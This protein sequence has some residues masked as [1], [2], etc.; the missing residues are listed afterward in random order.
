MK[1]TLLSIISALLITN[2]PVPAAVAA[3][4]NYF[5]LSTYST[6]FFYHNSLTKK[7]GIS[8]GTYG[9]F[10]SPGHFLEG[11]LNYSD[12]EFS[13]SRISGYDA[14]LSYTN[15]QLA[16][17]GLKIGTNLLGTSYADNDQGAVLFTGVKYFTS[18]NINLGVDFYTSFYR[19]Y[20]NQQPV[21]Q[22]TPSAGI[23]IGDFY[24]ETKGYYIKLPEEAII[25]N[26]D[27][28]SVEGALTY[29]YN[30]LFSIE[31]SGW[32]GDQAFAVRNSGFT[33][34]NVPEKH[35]AGYGL[36]FNYSFSKQ[37]KASVSWYNE[38]Y[39]GIG[40][41]E[42]SILVTFPIVLIYNF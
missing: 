21:F 8:V 26:K 28:L 14:V 23:N 9:Y 19:M 12:Y 5:Y 15:Y 16:N 7:N 37:L 38:H 40:N 25:E 4:K 39:Y 2:L 29:S 11:K 13:S 33:V 1:K 6:P 27:M 20:N 34:Y 35:F 30:N 41:S 17:T 24:L 10:S 18:F 22:F 31:G 36:A 42:Q 32:I 3:D